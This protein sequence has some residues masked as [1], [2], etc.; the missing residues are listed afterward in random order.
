LETE[1]LQAGEVAYLGGIESDRWL[2]SRYKC[3]RFARRP[4][5]GP[6]QERAGRATDVTGRKGE[7][8]HA[9]LNSLH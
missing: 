7:R 1:K 5:S 3:I 9:N 4:S 8:K 2:K 6:P